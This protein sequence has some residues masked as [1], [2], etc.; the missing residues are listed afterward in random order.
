MPAEELA[1]P[2][3]NDVRRRVSLVKEYPVV[4]KDVNHETKTIIVSHQLALSLAREKLL[5]DIVKGL[6]EGTPV[7]TKARVDFIRES[8]TS[9]HFLQLN[10]GGVGLRGHLFKN[11]WSTCYT[12]DIRSFAKVGDIIDVEIVDVLAPKNYKIGNEITT[13]S[14]K[15]VFHCSR[16]NTI[17]FNPWEGIE[18]KYPVGTT[19]IITCVHKDTG[20]FFAKVDG[21]SELNALCLYPDTDAF[22]IRE[23]GRYQAFVKKVIEDEKVLILKPVKEL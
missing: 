7:R 18:T 2:N 17:T 10:I 21:I 9:N 22:Y 8:T 11:D 13:S 15:V 23:G 4:V 16:K 3:H 20:K 14:K 6:E 5:K 19:V 12:S 1:G